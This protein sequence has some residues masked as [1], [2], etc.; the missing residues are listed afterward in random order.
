[1]KEQITTIVKKFWFVILVGCIFCSF[2][3]YFA[4]DTNKDKIPGKSVKGQD[5]IFT[6]ADV[7]Y[8]ADEYYE[9]LFNASNS[10]VKNGVAQLYL[11]ME[12]TV[13]HQLD[14]TKEM[15]EEV[16]VTAQSMETYYQNLYGSKYETY[17]NTQ[18]QML[19]YES[20]DD[21]ENFLLDQIKLDKII[22]SYIQE[23]KEL[24]ND[25]F[26]KS[27]P[28]V[29]SHILVAC[30]DPNNPTDAEKAKME[31]IEKA[32]K[33]S[34]FAEVA[35]QYSDDTGT[36]QTGGSLGLQL[37]DANLVAAFKSA[38]WKLENKKTSDWVK[39][40]YGYHL[41]RVDETSQ[42][43]I[44]K[45]ETY[46]ATINSKILSDNANLKKKIVWE[47]ANKLGIKFSNDELK[48]EM[49]DYIGVKE[50]EDKE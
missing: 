43:A 15:K 13:A 49:M 34:D 16:K 3:I 28:R 40:E 11:L 10:N 22:S 2:A 41:I 12:K 24:V 8:T 32:L 44:M 18:L 19:G 17:M 21:I 31:K 26:K 48:K 38:A 6:V 35:A 1:M 7:N 23:N 5:V 27:S 29:I 25:V 4:W 50:Q 14:A 45:N 39:T 37:N 9:S 36:I 33:K 46:A 20:V 30:S 47:E 42:K